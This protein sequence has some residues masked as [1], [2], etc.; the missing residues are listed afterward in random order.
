LLIQLILLFVAI[1]SEALDDD[2]FCN[3][4]HLSENFTQATA[5]SDIS[6]VERVVLKRANEMINGLTS[7]SI[8]FSGSDIRGKE[9]GSRKIKT[10]IERIEAGKVIKECILVTY[11]ITDT[12]ECTT[13]DPNWKHM[14]DS[15]ASCV[16][17]IGSYE[18]AC[19]NGTFGKLNSGSPGKSRWHFGR[20]STTHGVCWG[21][22]STTDCCHRQDFDRC[23]VESCVK[24]CVSDFKCVQDPCHVA[25]M[26]PAHSSCIAVPESSH[27]DMWASSLLSRSKLRGGFKCIC[28]E[29][30]YEDDPEG[31]GCRLKEKVDLCAN[32]SC[33]CDCHCVANEK[34]GGYTCSPDKGFK[35]V[36]A[37]ASPDNTGP[38]DVFPRR[39]DSGICVSTSVPKIQLY[40]KEPTRLQQGQ[41]YI[42]EGANI[43]ED[44]LQRARQRRITISYPDGPLGQCLSEIG[45]FNVKYEL[46]DVEHFISASSI[47]AKYR[48]VVVSDVDECSYDGQCQEFKAA[49]APNALCQNLRGSYNCTCPTPGYIGDGRLDGTGCVDTLLPI[50]QCEGRGCEPKVFHAA[51][52]HAFLSEDGQFN[53]TRTSDLSFARNKIWEY[54]DAGL[55]TQVDPF[56]ETLN[57]GRPC[58]FAFDDV[59]QDDPIV[60][61]RVDLSSQIKVGQLIPLESDNQTILRFHVEYFVSDAAGNSAKAYREIIVTA[62]PKSMLDQLTAGNVAHV[63]TQTM[64]YTFILSISLLL[65]LLLW[66]LSGQLAKL[67][68]VGPFALAYAALPLLSPN[69]T[70]TLLGSRERFMA[71]ADLWLV[72]SSLGSLNQ[73]ER[74]RIAMVEWRDLQNDL[75]D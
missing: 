64:W 1:A 46:D 5:P 58:F 35:K 47:A 55:R 65:A 40:G 60:P 49:C 72:V 59:F 8:V 71:A 15:S 45:T 6:K 10:L 31:G 20:T 4:M 50:I 54:H 56:C 2:V 52:F 24:T 44:D 37:P 13:D 25:A 19:R 57:A 41:H 43:V 67:I 26:C 36:I 16:N 32:H 74:L 53:E 42:E 18:C 3:E 9:I 70:M 12:N 66:T 23:D 63:L 73:H 7:V 69:L 21:H 28:D 38:I 30:Y 17:T 68:L 39:L 48:S 61:I 34:E 51:D 14:C 33:P 11:E 29:P 62:V 22:L 27:P 75:L